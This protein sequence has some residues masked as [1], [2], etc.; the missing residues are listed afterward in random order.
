MPGIRRADHDSHSEKIRALSQLGPHLERILNDH[1]FP[2]LEAPQ[3]GL[4]PTCKLLQ[5]HSRMAAISPELQ[6]LHTQWGIQYTESSTFLTQSQDFPKTFEYN[7]FFLP[8]TGD[9]FSTYRLYLAATSFSEA[10]RQ[11]LKKNKAA[12]SVD[13]LALKELLMQTFFGNVPTFVTDSLGTLFTIAESLHVYAPN[14]EAFLQAFH[15]L[16]KP[17]PQHPTRTT[18][19][20]LSLAPAAF[21]GVLEGGALDIYD[22]EKRVVRPELLQAF[23]ALKR[24]EPDSN[25]GGCPVGVSH[26]PGELSSVTKF[27]QHF[28]TYLDFYFD[29]EKYPQSVFINHPDPLIRYD[30][31][32]K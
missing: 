17:L 21:W 27:A 13:S 5:N 28:R 29:E 18:L 2:S 26:S 31:Q 1:F 8:V 15:Q 12:I 10:T 9:V 22:F 30:S 7:G 14:K 25:N 24:Q 23:S 32:R 20:A 6:Q 4:L 19:D 11:A 16:L 3:S